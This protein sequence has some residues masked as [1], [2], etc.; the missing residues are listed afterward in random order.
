[1]NLQ[2]K[3]TKL[4]REWD[5]AGHWVIPDSAVYNGIEDRGMV[6]LSYYP[7]AIANY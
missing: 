3:I 7:V 6:V 5:H 4:H 1:M 2:T